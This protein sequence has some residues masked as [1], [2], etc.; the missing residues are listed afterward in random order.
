MAI[1]LDCKCRLFQ[2]KIAAN[3]IVDR[4]HQTKL[5]PINWQRNISVSEHLIIL[6]QQN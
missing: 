3:W 2:T 1:C 4:Q 6:G 5:I